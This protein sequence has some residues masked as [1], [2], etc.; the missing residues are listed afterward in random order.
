M[1]CR[2]I[3]ATK[4]V[5]STVILIPVTKATVR[6]GHARQGLAGIGVQIDV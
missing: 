6:V 3:T 4:A 5:Q 1:E 2:V